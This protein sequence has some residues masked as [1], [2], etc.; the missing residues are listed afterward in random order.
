MNKS[1]SSRATQE[2]PTST[3]T[4]FLNNLN[5][6]NFKMKVVICFAVIMVIGTLCE[7]GQSRAGLNENEAAK[8]NQT[9]VWITSDCWTKDMLFWE[10]GFIFVLMEIKKG[11]VLLPQ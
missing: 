2:N 9:I 5:C 3:N 1:G 8:L 6:F 10:K 4:V 7:R 11:F